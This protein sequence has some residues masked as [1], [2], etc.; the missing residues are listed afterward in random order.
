MHT[1]AGLIVGLGN[2]GSKYECTRHNLGFMLVDRLFDVAG[3]DRRMVSEQAGA[4]F[5]CLLWKA[6]LPDGF[7]WLVAKPQTFRNRSSGI[8]PGFMRNCSQAGQ[9]DFS[10][11]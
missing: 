6:V 11:F 9:R 2:P 10:A 8:L 7:T 1:F 5:R 3:R 4:K